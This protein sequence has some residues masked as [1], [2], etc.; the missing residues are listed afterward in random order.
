M[1]EA[2]EGSSTAVSNPP[3]PLASISPSLQEELWRVA[4]GETCGLTAG[5][6]GAVLSAIGE[7]YN[8]GLPP[9]AAGDESQHAAFFRSLHL[10]E[11]A[12]AHACARGSEPAWERFVNLHR[13]ALVQAGTAIAGS[14]ALGTELADS[15]Y[16]EIYGLRQNGGERSSPLASYSG[17]GSL[18]GWLRANL[19]QRFRDHLR[20][21][22]R[23][24]PLEDFDGPVPETPVP[25]VAELSVLAGAVAQAL[26]ALTAED[27]FLLAA[28]YLD[29][30]TLLEIART[31]HVHEAT[32]SRRLKRVVTEA[33]K[34]LL[35]RLV[36]G[37]LNIT[38]AEEAL[39]A[40][41]RDVEINLRALLQSSQLPAFS[42]KEG[43][44][45]P[46]GT[47]PR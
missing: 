38:A 24:A 26:G 13:A 10:S 30:Q 27:Q 36:A 41:P 43:A 9:G 32:I 25:R 39:G 29:R 40:D 42:Y 17:R 18:A 22:R 11:L 5:E 8:H 34:Q 4:G 35:R 46:Q 45:Q 16:A 1:P 2:Q 20:R 28:Y 33:R 31:L 3:L 15:L 44:A 47:D 23:E 7:K 12:L 37:G 21:T 14:A 6:F 19:V